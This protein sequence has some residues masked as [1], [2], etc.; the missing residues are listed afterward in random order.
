[1]KAARINT[2][3]HADAI[4]IEEIDK[5][6]AAEGQVLVEVHAASINPF[7]TMVREGHVQSVQ[8]PLTLGGDI[9][10][11]VAEVGAS[12]SGFAV[13]QK[14]YGQANVVA[15]N[16][17]AFAEFAATKASQIAEMPTS[18]DF[19]QAAAMPLVGVSALQVITQHMNVQAGQKVLI[20]GGAGGIGTIAIQIAKHLGA[21]VTAT[22][23][24]EGMTYVKD[25]GADEVVDYTNQAF[26]EAEGVYDA[27]FDTVGGETYQRSFKTLKQGGVI[28]SMLM[29]PDEALMQQYN[30]RAI[31][32]Q[33]RVTTEDLSTLA[34]LVDQKV[35]TP[36]VD[37]TYPLAD[38]AEA[39]TARESGKVKGKVVLTIAA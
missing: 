15:G 5:P 12:V 19:V 24:G 28:V 38:V 31:A 11:V 33:T 32:R 25:L 14:V 22:A 8:P 10:G 27:V 20:H 13:G 9:A 30:V 6:Q 4:A 39:F 18:T 26:D 36:H 17:G 21:T 35:V 7:D 37:A 3:G 16:S 34:Q 1:M 2:F 23:T 29:Q